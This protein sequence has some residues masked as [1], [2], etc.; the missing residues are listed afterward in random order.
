MNSMQ[1]SLCR[2]LHYF[3]VS[4]REGVGLGLGAAVGLTPVVGLAG[5][6]LTHMPVGALCVESAMGFAY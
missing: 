5:G 4:Q 3:R 1:Y 6:P 2:R